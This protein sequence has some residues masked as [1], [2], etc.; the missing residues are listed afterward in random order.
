VAHCYDLSLCDDREEALKSRGLDALCDQLDAMCALAYRMNEQACRMNELG[1]LP[2]QRSALAY[3]RIEL[4]AL[5]DLPG[6]MCALPGAM[7]ALAYRMNELAYRKNALAQN[8]HHV[9]DQ[10]ALCALVSDALGVRCDLRQTSRHE[11]LALDA[12]PFRRHALM[13][14][15]ED[16]PLVRLRF[17]LTLSR[18]PSGNELHEAWSDQ[19]NVPL[20]ELLALHR[21]LSSAR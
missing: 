10:N 17:P 4:D 9:D 1:D 3:R 18:S 8:L 5:C 15:D 16:F 21:D 2:Y 7:C 19:I 20:Y 13:R 14:S 12:H 11:S 6:A